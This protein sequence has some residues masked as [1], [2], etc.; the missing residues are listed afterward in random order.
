MKLIE[1]SQGEQAVAKSCH[2]IIMQYCK[3]VYD[4]LHNDVNA[5]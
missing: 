3:Y 1:G 4:K 2:I 5:A